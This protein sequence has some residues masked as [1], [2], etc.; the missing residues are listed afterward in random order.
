MSKVNEESI[1][2]PNC[3]AKG[4]FDLWES[5]NV[6]LDPELREKIFSDEAF[7]YTC[8]ECGH[9]TG[10]PY[11]TLYHDMKHH[12]MLF[13]DF[14]KP[15]DFNYEPVDIP[16]MPGTVDYT[17]R[18]VTGLWRLKEKILILEKG[19]N[20]VAIERMKYMIKHI[21]YPE[22]GDK[23]VEM[24]FGGVDYADKELSDYGS[25]S[26]FYHDENDETM[27]ARYPLDRYFEQCKACELDSRMKVTR[28]EN[29][30]EGWMTMKL[31]TNG[32]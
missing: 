20:D 19:L 8:P 2:C 5:M 4:K 7:I 22:M 9:R 16:D 6:D 27:S 12:F 11:G 30:D 24:Y 26:F 3:K 1:I 29:V 10:V 32:A 18:H 25:I 21:L 14:F 17:Y 15:D 28:C 13:F 23:D 31:K